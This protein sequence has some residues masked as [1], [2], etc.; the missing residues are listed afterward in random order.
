[1]KVYKGTHA[2]Y[3]RKQF[4]ASFLS[5]IPLHEYVNYFAFWYYCVLLDPTLEQR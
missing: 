5:A 1:M 3:K 2:G 4:V